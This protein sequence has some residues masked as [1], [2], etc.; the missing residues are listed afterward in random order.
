[1]RACKLLPRYIHREAVAA[2]VATLGVS[3]SQKIFT[4]AR[5]TNESKA[6]RKR[7]HQAS[8]KTGTI[9]LLLF[10][11]CTFQFNNNTVLS[12]QSQVCL[13]FCMRRERAFLLLI[14]RYKFKQ[15]NLIEREKVAGLVSL[16][17]SFSRLCVGSMNTEQE[18]LI[19]RCC[20]CF[21]HGSVTA[22]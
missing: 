7:R 12:S 15:F 6:V 20:C 22:F 18:F 8:P 21:F 13:L 2:A 10:Q 17:F 3:M 1:M 11:V 14:L 9:G 16:S 4:S 19:F 5:N